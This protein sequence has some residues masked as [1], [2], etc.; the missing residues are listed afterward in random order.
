MPF[1]Q[2]R[3]MSENIQD[4]QAIEEA[5]TQPLIDEKDDEHQNIQQPTK[6]NLAEEDD[7]DVKPF[8]I[9]KENEECS[10]ITHNPRCGVHFHT[11]RGREYKCMNEPWGRI[12]LHELDLPRQDL[13]KRRYSN[14]LKDDYHSLHLVI[15]AF[16]N[17]NRDITRP[18]LFG[19]QKYSYT[20]IDF[21]L[22][23]PIQFAYSCMTLCDMETLR[24]SLLTFYGVKRCVCKQGYLAL[25]FDNFEQYV[26]PDLQKKLKGI[27]KD[28]NYESVEKLFE[29][30]QIDSK[31]LKK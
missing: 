14:I 2:F 17:E 10:Y 22:K 12:N 28:S 30:Y 6:E 15:I 20:L 1:T 7:G 13:M 31:Y 4:S 9:R 27:V 29:E 18:L 5:D 23:N 24:Q 11:K 8:K 21:L 19:N 25:S 26:D 3:K 16:R